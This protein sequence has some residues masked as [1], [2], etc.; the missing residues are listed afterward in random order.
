[1]R[2]ESRRALIKGVG[3]DVQERLYKLEPS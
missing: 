1:V 3:S 2:S